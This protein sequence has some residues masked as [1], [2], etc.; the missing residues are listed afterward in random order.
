MRCF[1]ESLQLVRPP[2]E[3]RALYFSEVF[4]VAEAEDGRCKWWWMGGVGDW[5]AGIRGTH[6]YIIIVFCVVYVYIYMS[7]WFMYI[8]IYLRTIYTCMYADS[9]TSSIHDVRRAREHDSTD[10]YRFVSYQELL[11]S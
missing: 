5:C 11:G 7:V 6:K 9:M 8:C 10:L 1:L 4:A 3:T 2:P